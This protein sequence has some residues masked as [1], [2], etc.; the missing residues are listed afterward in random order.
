MPCTDVVV[1]GVTALADQTG[2]ATNSPVFRENLPTLFLDN[3]KVS[4]LS[5]WRCGK[6]SS[7]VEQ[8]GVAWEERHRHERLPRWGL[9]YPANYGIAG[10]ILCIRLIVYAKKP[11]R[12]TAWMDARYTLH[13][14]PGGW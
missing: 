6:L 2:A 11:L 1:H 12:Y 7:C 4:V 8:G 10:S 14:T 3:R 9:Q 5:Y 13:P